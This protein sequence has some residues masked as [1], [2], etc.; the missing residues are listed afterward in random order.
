MF[1]SPAAAQA[2]EGKG[3]PEAVPGRR[4]DDGAFVDGQRGLAGGVPP[5][6]KLEPG[7]M[8]KL[9]T[10]EKLEVLRRC[11]SQGL[12]LLLPV[13]VPLAVLGRNR[14]VG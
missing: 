3:A 10:D 5:E 6:K 12:L 11:P 4:G 8:D 7:P 2:G 9:L 13:P 14:S 1:P